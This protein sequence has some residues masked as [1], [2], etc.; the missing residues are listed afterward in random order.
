M[1]TKII[2]AYHRGAPQKFNSLV[3]K[4]PDIFVPVLGGSI[5]NTNDVGFFRCM[6]RD[7]AGENISYLNPLFSE[8]T[9]LYWAYKHYT[10]IGNPDIIGFCHYR[11]FFDVDYLGLDPNVVYLRRG[12]TVHPEWARFNMH[13]FMGIPYTQLVMDEFVN[14]LPEY[15]EAVEMVLNDYN[16]FDKCMF[17]MKRPLFFE[18]MKY[19]MRCYRVV[20]KDHIRSMLV[21]WMIEYPSGTI[22]DDICKRPSA[23]YYLE[24]M[25]AVFFTQLQLLGYPIHLTP[26]TEDSFNEY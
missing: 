6:Q 18:L 1:T 8:N 13:S 10:E 5:L 25:M 23:S 24:N 2:C 20:Q 17:I 7:D 15:K 4:H 12:H 26:L 14:D 16:F 9:V 21:N 19:M 3:I 22:F 11:R